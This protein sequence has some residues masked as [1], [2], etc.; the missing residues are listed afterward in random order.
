MISFGRLEGYNVEKA[1]FQ[2][3][4]CSVHGACPLTPL[5]PP[6]PPALSLPTLWI[7]EGQL[8]NWFCT[9]GGTNLAAGVKCSVFYARGR[10]AADW[11]RM[12]RITGAE[13]TAFTTSSTFA[14]VISEQ[15]VI[16]TAFVVCFTERLYEDDIS[17]ASACLAWLRAS[18]VHH[19]AYHYYCNPSVSGMRRDEG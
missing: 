13:E 18:F 19:V 10:A 8:L 6:P 3:L 11:T 17:R 4:I 5:P 15:A 9:F 7:H 1:F 14:L 12:K 16:S 2:T